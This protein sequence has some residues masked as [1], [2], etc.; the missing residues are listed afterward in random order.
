MINHLGS[1]IFVKVIRDYYNFEGC[2]KAGITVSTSQ[3]LL[4][5]IFEGARRLYPKEAVLL[6]RGEK[7]ENLIR[8]SEL[9]VPPLATYGRGFVN[10]RLHMLPMDFSIVGTVHSHPSGSLTPSTTDL[11]HF[12]GNILMI[13]GFPFEDERNVAVYNRSGRKL[14]LHVTKP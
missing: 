3:E 10:I 4:Q 1:F 6:L 13:V 12:F 14:P 7:K 8:I 2:M 5:A 9:V 11:N